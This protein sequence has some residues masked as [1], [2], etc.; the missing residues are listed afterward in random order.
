[1]LAV[2]LSQNCFL[3]MQ[4]F[5]NLVVENC[6]LFFRNIIKSESSDSWLCP[7]P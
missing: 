2:Q 4:T 6:V 5:V 1:M 3:K 7:E